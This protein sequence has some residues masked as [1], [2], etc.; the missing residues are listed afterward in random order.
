MLCYAWMNPETLIYSRDAN[1]GAAI[2]SVVRRLKFESVR[3]SRVGAALHLLRSR[4]FPA[5]IVD[6]LDGA[7]A[8]DLLE[9]C[10]C[11][12]SNKSSI[13]VALTEG[14]E[15]AISWRVNFAVRR[16]ADQDTRALLTVLRAAEGL[17]RQEFRRYRRIPIASLAVLENDEHSLQLPTVNVSEGGMC[18]QGE[19]FGWNKEHVV[20]FSHPDMGLR[21]Q[22][23]SFVVWSRSGRSGLQ[24]RFM[25]VST[26]QALFNWLEAH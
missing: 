1:L 21:F 7:A 2:E 4:K 14:S 5:V 10:R 6:C 17:I 18:I 24:F 13:V 9:L 8:A 25:S 3:V 16:P 26:Q 15:T 12:G 19:V 20:H 22:A 11:S 23:K